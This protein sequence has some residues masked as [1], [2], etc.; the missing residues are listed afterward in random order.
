MVNLKKKNVS[1]IFRIIF[2]ELLDTLP[3]GKNLRKI[4][5]NIHLQL[6]NKVQEIL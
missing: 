3:V 1:Y 6:F 2:S 4:S 5:V